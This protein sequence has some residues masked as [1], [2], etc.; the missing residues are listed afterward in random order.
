M[1]GIRNIRNRI[2]ITRNLVKPAI[3]RKTVSQTTVSIP[4]TD[5]ISLMTK[6]GAHYVY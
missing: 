2:V 3:L 6:P 4:Q 5:T 1:M